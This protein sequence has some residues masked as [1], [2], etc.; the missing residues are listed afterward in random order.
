MQDLSGSWVANQ[1][2]DLRV[3]GSEPEAH[4]PSAKN[5][6][7]RTKLKSFS[8]T[9]TKLSPLLS[10]FLPAFNAIMVQHQ[11]WIPNSKKVRGLIGSAQ[12]FFTKPKSVNAVERNDL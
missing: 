2:T 1:T 11:L 5:P 8:G 12:S 7:R 9:V 6:S 10:D 4:S 3:G